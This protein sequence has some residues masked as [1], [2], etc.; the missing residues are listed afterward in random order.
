MHIEDLESLKLAIDTNN[1]GLY[2]GHW[3]DALSEVVDELLEVKNREDDQLSYEEDFADAKL[4][5][6][7]AMEEKTH[8]MEAWVGRK[9]VEVGEIEEAIED[10]LN[11]VARII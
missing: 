3:E 4:A 7:Q 10:I 11:I 9:T 8:I 1:P 5:V 2:H 6:Q